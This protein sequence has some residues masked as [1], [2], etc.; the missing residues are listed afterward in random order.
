MLNVVPVIR[1]AMN[2]SIDVLLHVEPVR[3]RHA[4]VVRAPAT[5]GGD[6]I[7]P[8]LTDD[9]R[10]GTQQDAFD[11]AEDRRVRA[12]SEREAQNRQQRESRVAQEQA[13]GV[14]RVA[15]EI[16]EP[17]KHVHVKGAFPDEGAI[18]EPSQ[19]GPAGLVWR[20]AVADVSVGKRVEMEPALFLEIVV[21]LRPRRVE[22]PQPAHEHPPRRNAGICRSPW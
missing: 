14:R 4:G 10:V 5:R 8:I 7:Q 16:V 6:R 3:P 21:A 15:A 2:A 17:A 20:H 12:D 19:R 18:A 11:P 1:S 9:E 13:G 22:P